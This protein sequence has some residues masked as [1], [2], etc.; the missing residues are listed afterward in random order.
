MAIFQK[1]KKVFAAARHEEFRRGLRHAVAPAIEHDALLRSL[2]PLNSIVDV[3]A[4]RGQ[5]ALVARRIQPAAKITA[6]EPLPTAGRRFSQVFRDDDNVTLHSVAIGKCAA[7]VEFHVSASD[8]SSSLLPITDLQEATFPGTKQRRVEQVQVRPLSELV[9]SSDLAL[10]ALLKIDVQGAEL[11]VLLGVGTLLELFDYVCVEASFV[12]FYSGQ[13]LVHEILSHM[14]DR[15]F[16]LSGVYNPVLN[17][18]GQSVQADFLFT[19]S[20][21]HA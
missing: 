14:G 16:I 7:E 15:N 20:T 19:N 5:F 13:P 18:K 12:E 3:G 2:P 11:D 9:R 4:N 21:R 17:G 1:A 8:D 10:P 6:F